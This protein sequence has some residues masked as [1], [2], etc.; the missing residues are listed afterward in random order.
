MNSKQMEAVGDFWMLD[1]DVPPDP[2]ATTSKLCLLLILIW[3][4]L[5]Y[6]HLLQAHLIKFPLK[7]T[8]SHPI[9]PSGSHE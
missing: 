9:L 8:V 2:G 5:V 3:L 7:C 1:S 4:M 6:N